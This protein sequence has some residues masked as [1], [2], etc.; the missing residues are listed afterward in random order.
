MLFR[1]DYFV[2]FLIFISGSGLLL[3]SFL[4]SKLESG[5]LATATNECLGFILP[6]EQ[7]Q[8]VTT[9]I[10]EYVVQMKKVSNLYFCKY[11]IVEIITVIYISSYLYFL[12]W[13][14]DIT[15]VGNV[16]DLVTSLFEVTSKR[17]D[18]LMTIFPREVKC[19]IDNYGPSGTLQHF[20]ARCVI[21]NQGYNE[22][23][24][25][26]ALL[27]SVIFLVICF[28]NALWIIITFAMFPSYVHFVLKRNVPLRM[29]L[30]QILFL[31]LLKMNIDLLTYKVLIVDLFDFKKDDKIDP[32]T[33]N[34]DKDCKGNYSYKLKKRNGFEF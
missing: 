22:L 27:T 18:S 28:I 1:S 33:T 3:L 5:H 23:F 16:R 10:S 9:C 34:L 19:A 17:S 8:R 11:V 12:L 7:R 32:A 25:I 20:D 31:C 30:D 13:I 4:W 6:K 21:G 15:D 24:H 14:L 29:N 26:I 2:Q